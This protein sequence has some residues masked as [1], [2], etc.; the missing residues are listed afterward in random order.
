MN[1]PF[2]DIARTLENKYIVQW[3]E[4]GNAVIGYTCSYLPDEILYSMG[5]LPFRMRGTGAGSTSIGDTY[6]GPF[7]CSMPKCILQ[8]AGEG[9][10]GFLDGAVVI[11]GCDSMRRMDDCWRKAGGDIEGAL[12]EFF[13]HLGVPHKAVDYS[14]TW[15]RQEIEEFVAAVEKHFSVKINEDRLRE[16]VKTYN[17]GRKLLRELQE[18]RNLK[19][20]PV[21]GAESMAVIL[22]GSAIPRDIFNSLLEE[23][24]A[25]LRLRKNPGTKKRIL[26]AGSAND[27]VELLQLIEG[28]KAVVV[29]DNICFGTRFHP[30]I[31]NE[32]ADPVSA[33][34]EHYLFRSE[35]PRMFGDYKK[36]YSILREKIDSAGVDGVILQN[37]RFCDLHGSENGLFERDLEKEGI[38][39]MRLERE[40][41][42]MVETG[43]VKMRVDAFLERIG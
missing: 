25:E 18:L 39:S 20:S 31:V 36:R 3:K 11:P 21:S 22:A 30:D 8:L 6:F 33:L 42:P 24:L 27:D 34:A 9:S 2:M 4:N 13:H 1:S 38:P 5:I 41:G 32:D 16:S 15:F 28:D 7:I 37:I 10:Y 14:L 29:A 12:P 40:Y 19:S 23:Y 43:R 26:L 17:R 35:C